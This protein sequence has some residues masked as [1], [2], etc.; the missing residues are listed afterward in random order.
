MRPRLSDLRTMLAGQRPTP[1]SPGAWVIFPI[2]ER[3][4]ERSDL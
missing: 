4:L 3:L 2:S 1:C